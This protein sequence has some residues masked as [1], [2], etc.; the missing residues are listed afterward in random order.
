MKSCRTR[1]LM[2]SLFALSMGIGSLMPLYAKETKETERALPNNRIVFDEPVS[3]GTLPGSTGNWAGSYPDANRWQQLSLPIG[4]SLMG[5]NIFGEVGRERLTFNQ[6]TVW[7]GGPAQ[8]RPDYNGG[9]KTEIGGKTTAEFYQDV[10]DAFENNAADKEALT[11]QLVGEQD[12]YGAYQMLADIYLDFEP[13]SRE[14]DEYWQKYWSTGVEK[15]DD[16]DASISYTG[17]NDYDKSGWFEGTEKY[18]YT[19]GAELNMTFMGSAVRMIGARNSECGKIDVYLDGELVLKDHVLT[20]ESSSAVDGQVLFELAETGTGQHTLRIVNKGGGSSDKITYDYFEVKSDESV[21]SEIVDLNPSNSS[22]TGVQYSSDWKTWSRASDVDAADW[23]NTEEMY[24]ENSTADTYITYTFNGTGI[25]LWGAKNGNPAAHMG[26]FTWSIDGSEEQTV[27]C[28]RE[29]ATLLRMELFSQTGLEEGEH[30]LMIKGVDNKLSFDNF[31]VYGSAKDELVKPEPPKTHTETENYSR[32]LDI[33]QALAGVEYDRDATHYTREYFASHPDNVIAMKFGASGQ[34]TLDFDFS[35]PMALEGDTADGK[36]TRTTGAVDGLEAD[37]SISGKLNDNE[38][39]I[40]TRAK[41]VIDEG[42]IEYDNG[43]L[44]IRNAGEATIFVSAATDYKNEYPE[45]RT[46]E[47]DAQVLS[48]ADSDVENAAKKGYAKVREDHI[49]DYTGIYD[50]MHIDLGQEKSDLT[51]DELLKGYQEKTIGEAERRY[52]ETEL[53]QYGRYLQISSSREN[54]EGRNDQDLPANLQGVWSIYAGPTSVVPWAGDYHMNVNLQMNYWPSYTTN[55]AE[56]AL[57]MI[58]Y[59]DS[60]REP[61]RVTASTYFGIDNSNGQ[62]NGYT[63]HTQNTPFGWTC[64]G[65]S[66]DWGWSPAA[67]PW[68]LQNVYEYYEYTGDIQ[69]LKEKIFPMMREQAKLYETILRE[70]T[71]A[72]GKTRLGT[73]PAYSPEHGP[74]TAGNVY[75]NS[76]VWQLFNDCIEAANALNEKEPGTVDEATIAKWIEIREKLD[77]IEIGDSGQIKEWYDETTLGSVS[78]A[79]RRHRH[80]S[81][82]LGLYPGDLINADHPDFLEAAKVSLTDRGDEGVGWGLAQRMS[83]WARVKDGEHA[84]KLVE[85]LFAHGIY[86]N[87][88]DSCA[89]FQIDGNFGYTAGVT[90][91][92]MQSNASTIE[93]LPALPAVWNS[94]SIDGVVAR[95]NFELSYEW[96]DGKLLHAQVLANNGGTCRLSS[97]EFANGSVRVK[98]SKGNVIETAR[99]EGRDDAVSFETI[100][101][102]LYTI[103]PDSGEPVDPLDKSL[104]ERVV[105]TASKVIRSE[106]KAQSLIEFDRALEEARTM[107]EEGESQS[108]VN[109]STKNLHRALFDLRLIPNEEKLKKD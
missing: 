51:T 2:S 22:Q 19:A 42:T 17:W 85:N 21:S 60:L 109:D 9:N 108:S 78:G 106:F 53:Y 27:N 56:C 80:M 77:P 50:R 49:A 61:G 24:V 81:H 57:P 64:P 107:L 79:D 48:R 91:M 94:G 58:E 11:S 37:L 70:V 86:N 76:L 88:W 99:I 23:I 98:D 100:K 32:W 101:G 34:E 33:D 35:I 105:D 52:L 83:S 26:N 66:F 74:K 103:E 92:L 15:V 45:Y 87:F 12:G 67:V 5:A 89:P 39:K 13:G 97:P 14:W 90:E 7:N 41:V 44:C 6:K 40:A 93:L 8:K 25:A 73:V 72:N 65:W 102:E 36:T 1:R 43:V 63:A 84:Y 16:R 30:T 96:N 59:E 55:M 20:I 28:V 4:N 95:G 104:L 18:T 29:E 38:M 82:L 46:G 54:A 69:Y 75:E 68:M 31:V 10:V 3:E 62:E 47:S 71:Y